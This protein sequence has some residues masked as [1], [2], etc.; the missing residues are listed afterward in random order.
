MLCAS[1]RRCRVAPCARRSGATKTPQQ[2]RRR[3]ARKPIP[4]SPST[5]NAFHQ[6]P[7]GVQSFD[8]GASRPVERVRPTK[9]LMPHPTRRTQNVRPPISN[10]RGALFSELPA[11]QRGAGLEPA[12]SPVWMLYPAELPAPLSA[13]PDSNRRP[14]TLVCPCGRNLT[15]RHGL[16]PL[17]SRPCGLGRPSLHGPNAGQHN[18]KALRPFRSYRTPAALLV[19]A[20]VVSPPSGKAVHELLCVLSRYTLIRC[21]S[22]DILKKKT[23]WPWPERVA[24]RRP[25][26]FWPGRLSSRAPPSPARSPRAPRGLRDRR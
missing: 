21:A 2:E 22:T 20:H 16:P 1:S 24:Q 26:S 5:S 7:A 18:Q 25:G 15:G 11:P 19:A 3:S 13:G 9:F 23:T 12:T 4:F 10:S 14:S 6:L 17:A 8:L